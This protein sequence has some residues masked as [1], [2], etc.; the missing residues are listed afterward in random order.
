MKRALTI[1]RDD[2]C[3]IHINDNT[4][5]VSRHHAIVEVGRFG[6]YYIV[7]QSRNG[8]YVNGLRIP[9]QQRYEIRR[10][11]EISLAH[12]ALLNWEQVPK[13]NTLLYLIIGIVST[14]IVVAAVVIGVSYFDG[15]PSSSS[16]DTEWM[17]GNSGSFT[18][19]DT[20]PIGVGDDG[21][22]S[23]GD[24]GNQEGS[25]DEGED[26]KETTPKQTKPKSNKK[27]EAPKEAEKAVVDAIY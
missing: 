3:D 23:S 27:T 14:L 22:S 25:S 5:I 26:E 4:D 9:S 17:S 8:T 2:S 11:D 10:G 24:E 16:A 20:N 13:D 18:P 21:G 6:K 12:T 1:G 15:K 7:D 19:S